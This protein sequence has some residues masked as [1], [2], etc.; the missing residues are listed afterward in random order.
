MREFASLFEQLNQT[1][2]TKQKLSLLKDYFQHAD[3][4]DKVWAIALFTGRR[5]KRPIN[6]TQL[7]TY[8]IEASGLPQWL[9]EESYHVAGDLAETIALL[10]PFPEKHSVIKVWHFTGSNGSQTPSSSSL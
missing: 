5:P 2:K 10:L 9:F 8:A 3:D 6:S 1:N 7:R 4:K